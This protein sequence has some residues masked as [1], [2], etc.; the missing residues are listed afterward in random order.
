VKSQTYTN[1][2][3]ILIDDCSSDNSYELLLSAAKTDNRIRVFNNLVNSKAFETRNVGL[4]N[5][6][7]RFIAFLD[8]D[9]I[10]HP[11]KLE[12]QIKFMIDAQAAI[13]YTAFRRFQK[14]PDSSNKVI[15]ILEKVSLRQLL[16]NTIIVTSSVIVDTNKTSNFEMEDVYYDD[17]VLWIRLLSRVKHAFGFNEPLLYY[18]VSNNSLSRNKLNSIVKVYGIFRNNLNLGII[19]AHI[20]FFLWL[21]NAIVRYIFLY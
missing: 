8:A 16:T 15:N 7:G 5:A 4:R 18:R 20:Y 11:E 14:N 17:F 19:E 12:K 6:T 2:E 1:W 3:L 10:W 21:K 13:S 9:D